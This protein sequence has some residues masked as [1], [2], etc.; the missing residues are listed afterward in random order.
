MHFYKFT[1]YHCSLF[2]RDFMTTEQKTFIESIANYVQK[3]ASSYGIKVHSPIIAQAILESGWGKSKLAAQYHNYFGLKCGSKWT[4]KSVN[5]TTQ[6]EYTVGTLTTIKDN[7]RVYD[8]MEDGIKGYFEFIQ[9]T[10]YQNLKGITDPQEYLETIK[11]DGYATSST[12]VTNNMKLVTQYN[13]T[14]YD[15]TSTGD[16]TVESN[17]EV[18]NMG[19]TASQIINI[20]RGWIGKSRSAGTHKDIIDLYNS[21]TPRARGYKVTY[22]DAYCDTT[23]SAAFIKAGD[24]SIIGGTEC[25]V[26]NHIELFKKAGIWEE[27]GTITP[28]AG[29]I[30]CFNWDD[31]TQ[32]NDGYADHIGIVESVS[33]GK[34]TCI[35]GNMSGGIVGRRTISVGWGYIRGYAKPKYAAETS[36]STSS[37]TNTTTS[38]TA[39]SS[40]TTLNKTVKWNGVVTASEL[41]VRTYAG[42]SNKTV[43][44]SPLKKNA[45]VGVCDSVKDSSGVVWYYIK[46]N[47]KY[48]FVSSKYITKQT[49]STTTS[50]T[51]STASTVKVEGAASFLKSLAGTYKTTANL[52]LRT[53]AGTNKTKQCTIPKGDKVTCYGYYTSVSGVKWYLVTYENYKGFVSSLYLKK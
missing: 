40:G 28:K 27:D 49:S 53:G 18:K 13:L 52:N 22:T 41:N 34:I 14:Q 30:I 37:S 26:Q 2:R 20:M 25:G 51:T 42:T 11:N 48:G 46:Y 33:N 7:F 19:V 24:V 39:S 35:E 17:T 47:N 9:L 8:S 6:E 50:T 29:Y 21:Y 44:F 15:S 16:T 10:R 45:V 4:G 3:Y 31:G 23:V 36:S 38:N 5:L 1:C 32:P 12:Y 43:S